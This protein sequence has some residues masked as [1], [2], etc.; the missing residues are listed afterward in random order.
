MPTIS[1]NVLFCDL[2][3]DDEHTIFEFKSGHWAVHL[4]EEVHDELEDALSNEH[5]S[6]RDLIV[7]RVR[8]EPTTKQRSQ[9]IVERIGL[10]S[11][12]AAGRQLQQVAPH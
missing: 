6:R 9:S 5:K 8:R 1:P 10:Q 11:P 2:A 7:E 12:S 4:P 3:E